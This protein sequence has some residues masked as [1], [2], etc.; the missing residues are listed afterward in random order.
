MSAAT[1]TTRPSRY[2]TLVARTPST[3]SSA[4]YS[5]S[6]R[7]ARIAAVASLVTALNRTA[8]Y[9]AAR[10]ALGSTGRETSGTGPSPHQRGRER[11]HR[12]T[13]GPCVPTASSPLKV[14]SSRACARRVWWR[15][16]RPRRLPPHRSTRG[17]SRRKAQESWRV[18]S[19][20]RE[21]ALGGRS[22]RFPNRRIAHRLRRLS[23]SGRRKP[24][25]GGLRSQPVRC[26]TS[27]NTERRGCPVAARCLLRSWSS[28]G[29]AK[30]EPSHRARTRPR[31]APGRAP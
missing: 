29:L 22:R 28:R 7:S 23:Q 25:K 13:R 17:S 3:V 21:I 30:A 26:D 16:S 18:G 10:T 5:A 24:R 4:Q 20:G 1:T 6:P 9:F 8:K 27:R 11:D 12:C 15:S 31:R 14:S 2:G 19:S